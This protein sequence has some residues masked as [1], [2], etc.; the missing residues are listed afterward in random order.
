MNPPIPASITEALHEYDGQVPGAA[1]LI[2]RD[3]R[4]WL[5]P[6]FISNHQKA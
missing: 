5:F 6:S 4:P 1:L 3:G 2:I